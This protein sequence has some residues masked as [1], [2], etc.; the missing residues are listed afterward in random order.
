M[1]VPIE[2]DTLLTLET[3]LFCAS[4]YKHTLMKL[5]IYSPENLFQKEN[6]KHRLT[7]PFSAPAKTS[8]YRNRV[9]GNF[10]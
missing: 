10:L 5:N 3:S 6:D 8:Q 2:I 4:V 1:E 7:A 9:M